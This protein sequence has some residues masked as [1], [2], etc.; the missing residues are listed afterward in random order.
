M[1]S[2]SLEQKR[3]AE[4]VETVESKLRKKAIFVPTLDEDVKLQVLYL[5]SFQLTIQLRACGEPIC[6]FGE[7][8]ADRRERLRAV[9]DIKSFAEE[10]IANQRQVLGLKK[11]S[12]EEEEKPKEVVYERA[13]PELIQVRRIIYEYSMKRYNI[14]KLNNKIVVK[15][16]QKSNVKKIQI[17]SC[18]LR[19]KRRLRNYGINIV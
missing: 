2:F 5:F 11:Q 7:G 13:S 3:F 1:N 9:L 18:L 19:M 17:W 12:T 6:L 10:D 14:V 16:D 4:T 15:K 8:P